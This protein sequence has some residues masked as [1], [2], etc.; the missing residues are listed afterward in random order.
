MTLSRGLP[1]QS[2]RQSI[3]GQ[4]TTRSVNNTENI[5][6]TQRVSQ[7]SNGCLHWRNQ[8]SETGSGFI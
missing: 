3:N 7:V 1:D 8:L 2:Q 6:P 5:P 4:T